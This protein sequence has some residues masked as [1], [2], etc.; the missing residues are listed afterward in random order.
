MD[1]DRP[2]KN[3]LV[4]DTPAGGALVIVKPDGRL[5]YGPGYTPDA[6]A[7]ALWEALARKRVE[8]ERE[9][10]NQ[11]RLATPEEAGLLDMERR[12][13]EWEAAL[14]ALAKADAA[15]EI[16]QTQ[17]NQLIGIVSDTSPEMRRANAKVAQTESAG[18][19][20]VAAVVQ[21]ARAHAKR[22]GAVYE[23]YATDQPSP[24]PHLA[25]KTL[26]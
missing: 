15:N 25:K 11:V 6:A 16:A 26:N 18:D 17:R 2:S 7:T 22:T 9:E 19:E 5:V 23:I 21:L 24:E 20:A 3:D 13:H 12:F 4:I 8:A 14:I 1:D 10:P